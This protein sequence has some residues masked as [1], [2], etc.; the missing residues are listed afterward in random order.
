MHHKIGKYYVFT[1]NR[2]EAIDILKRHLGIGK[3]FL[4]VKTVSAV[5]D[6]DS[7]SEAIEK[8]REMEMKD[9]VETEITVEEE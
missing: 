5:V 8:F 6:A 2:K 3:K 4:V 1:K 9:M 7:E